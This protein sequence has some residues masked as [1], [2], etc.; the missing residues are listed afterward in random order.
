MNPTIQN[1][2]QPLPSI[3]TVYGP[4]EEFWESSRP[5]GGLGSEPSEA[6]CPLDAFLIHRL[7]ELVPGRPLLIDAALARTGGASSLIGLAH[8]QVRRVWV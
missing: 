3:L 5:A 7:L 4:I 6:I 8:P 1:K 2:R